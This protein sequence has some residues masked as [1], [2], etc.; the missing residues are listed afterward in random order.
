[1]FSGIEEGKEKPKLEWT[2]RGNTE[3]C[4]WLRERF[5]IPNR[6][7][8]GEESFGKEEVSWAHFS[9]QGYFLILYGR[10]MIL[11]KNNINVSTTFN[12]S[13]LACDI[14]I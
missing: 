7:W 13:M 6:A 5:L 10:E 9:V 11:A 12:F 8:P 1:M 14:H 3:D 2:I 4:L